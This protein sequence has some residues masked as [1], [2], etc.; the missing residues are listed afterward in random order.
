M[1][2][3]TLIG[4]VIN[5]ALTFMEFV[6]GIVGNSQAVVADAVHSLSD[7]VT[8]VAVL[9]G[10]R[11]WSRPPDECHPHGHR[12]IEFL[13]TIFIG[14]ILAAVALGI[15]Y[16][17]LATL[18]DPQRKPPGA[19]AFFAA[20][21]MIFTKEFL[22]Q[23]TISVGKEIRSPALIASAWHHRSDALSSIP[24]AAAVAGAA[25]VP[26][27]SFLDH[28]GAIVISAFI[29]QVA[30]KI[31]RPS[32]EQLVD[33]GAPEEIRRGIEQLASATPGV[34]EVHAIRTRHIG[35]GIEVDLHVLVDP[36]LTVEEGHE[37]SEEVKRRLIEYVSDVVDVVVHLEPYGDEKEGRG[38]V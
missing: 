21:V 22:Y 16:N 25:I 6:A 32:L 23:W 10:V 29:L 37:I 33:L 34:E 11:F 35:S 31:I 28:L 5:L 2:R 24:A 36:R 14:L 18:H 4:V 19:V 12:R 3:L 26:G 17:A 30:W 20:V 1:R 9:V 8:G 38:R 27:L 15:G 7:T 13:V